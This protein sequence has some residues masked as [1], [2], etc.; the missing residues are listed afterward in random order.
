ML[1]NSV[2]RWSEGRRSG[3]CQDVSGVEGKRRQ[4]M[5]YNDLPAA[6]QPQCT[7]SQHIPNKTLNYLFVF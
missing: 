3:K 4:M 5:Q 2:R 6:V 7:S 1:F